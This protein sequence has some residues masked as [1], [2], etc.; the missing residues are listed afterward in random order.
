MEC[1][2]KILNDQDTLPD[3]YIPPRDWNLIMSESPSE[4]ICDMKIEGVLPTL[5]N[6]PGQ[7]SH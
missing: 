5:Q 6:E 1:M 3:V 4:M 7:I 2:Y